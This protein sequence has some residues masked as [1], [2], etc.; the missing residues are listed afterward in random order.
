MAI[1]PVTSGSRSYL[2]W[3]RSNGL[4][5]LQIERGQVS[6]LRRCVQVAPQHCS[7]FLQSAF[8]IALGE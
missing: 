6:V 3:L 7:T 1:S 4:Q 5:A 2:R 8:G